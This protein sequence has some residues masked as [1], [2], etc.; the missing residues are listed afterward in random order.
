MPPMSSNQY[1]RSLEALEATPE[2]NKKILRE[3]PSGAEELELSGLDRR[4]FLEVMGASL[5]LGGVTLTGCIRK[6]REKI[7]PFSKRPEDLIPGKPRYYATVT[8][9]GTAVLG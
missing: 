8:H 5:A 4:R 6:P 9:V 1:W 3:F 7:L 2:L